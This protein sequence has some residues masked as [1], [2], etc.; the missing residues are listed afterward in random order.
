MFTII[1]VTFFKNYNLDHLYHP[2]LMPELY[3]FY[4]QTN[5]FDRAELS[6]IKLLEKINKREFYQKTVMS[7]CT[8][9]QQDNQ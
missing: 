1:K 8:V 5:N 9:H 3:I 2:S 6:A 4:I 7:F